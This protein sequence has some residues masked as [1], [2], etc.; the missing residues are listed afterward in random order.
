M[1]M[2]IDVTERTLLQEK[3][4][5]LAT[6]DSLTGIYNRTHFMELSRGLLEEAAERSAPFRSSCWISISSK[7]SMTGTDTNMAIWHCSM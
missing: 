4:L 1:I 6:I 7:A 3:L 5:Q 2:L